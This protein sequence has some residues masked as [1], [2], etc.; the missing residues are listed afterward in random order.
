MVMT[1]TAVFWDIG[2]CPVPYGYDPCLVG[3][4]IKSELKRSGISGPITITA[5]G[6]LKLIPTDVLKSLSSSGIALRNV[7]QVSELSL[8][9]NRLLWAYPCVPSEPSCFSAVVSKTWLW[10][11]LLE[12]PVDDSDHELVVSKDKCVLSRPWYCSVCHVECHSF[13]DFTTHLKSE[14]H[15]KR[16]SIDFSALSKYCINTIL[17]ISSIPLVVYLVVMTQ[18]LHFLGLIEHQQT[19]V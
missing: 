14:Q 13:E 5:L 8:K 11:S 15:D 2:S 19:N 3:P 16:V 4:V 17:F 6:K 18:E 7:S 1:K 12:A 10:T 9:G